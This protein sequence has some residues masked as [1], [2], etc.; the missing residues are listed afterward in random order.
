MLN[1]AT[2]TIFVFAS[3][4]HQV[5]CF[6]SRSCLHVSHIAE[7]LSTYSITIF[8]QPF[9]EYWVH[10][11]GSCANELKN[12]EKETSVFENVFPDDTSDVLEH[13]ALCLEP[14][15]M[16]TP[17]WDSDSNSHWSHLNL[18]MLVGSSMVTSSMVFSCS[19]TKSHGLQENWVSTLEVGW[20]LDSMCFIKMSDV[21]QFKLHMSHWNNTSV[22]LAWQMHFKI[23]IFRKYN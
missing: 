11:I 5:F 7:N 3:Q 20:W 12:C 14:L 16:L 21:L 6:K 18:S 8:S 4:T 23:S 1:K 9:S 17:F 19:P 10:K 22:E 2:D 13:E 15:W